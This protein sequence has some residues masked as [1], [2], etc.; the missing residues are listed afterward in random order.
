MI[1]MLTLTEIKA[2]VDE[3]AGKIGASGYVL[4]TYGHS[5][6]G[7]RPHIEVDS[8]GYHYVVVERGEEL[9]RITTTS[10]DDLLYH[11]FEAVTF[12]LAGDY[13]VTH[14]I[15]GQ[16]FRILLFKHQVELLSALSTQWA[17][18]TSARHER[19]LRASKGESSDS[20]HSESGKTPDV[21]LL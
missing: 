14:R 21:I 13:E 11:I 5:E 16:D 6:D 19:L 1:Y 8:Q 18:R 15:P 7:A 2:K 10:L 4:P 9:K 20:S 17:E 3:L 12:S